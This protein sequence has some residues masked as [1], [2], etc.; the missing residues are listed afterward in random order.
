MPAAKICERLKGMDQ[1]ICQVK[2]EKPKEKVDLTK[3]DF[4]KMRVKELKQTLTAWSDIADR[5]TRSR[6]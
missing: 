1:E 6:D 4:D 3:V 2:Y 5:Q